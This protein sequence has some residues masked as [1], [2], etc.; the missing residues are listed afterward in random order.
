MKRE[1]MEVKREGAR[2]WMKVKENFRCETG[3]KREGDMGGGWGR[4]ADN[5]WE[6]G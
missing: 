1:C 4:G 5:K 3:K 2:G 6:R